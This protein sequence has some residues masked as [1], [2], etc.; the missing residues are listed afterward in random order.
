LFV[1]AT[2]I[3]AGFTLE[4]SDERSGKNGRVPECLAIHTESNQKVCVEAK[5]RNVT[6]V[7]GSTQGRSK[8][9]KLYDKLKYKMLNKVLQ[10]NGERLRLLLGA[11]PRCNVQCILYDAIFKNLRL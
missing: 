6:N 2:L 10:D 5:T 1:F 7:L 11:H 4:Y 9:I 3:R 8:K